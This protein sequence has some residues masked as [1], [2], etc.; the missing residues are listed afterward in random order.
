M[1]KLTVEQCERIIAN[2]KSG[3]QMTSVALYQQLADTMRENERLRKALWYISVGSM[4]DGDEVPVSVA[5][6]AERA[7]EKQ[8]KESDNG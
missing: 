4:P 8:N 1:N 5:L 2:H 3:V 7:L 6:W